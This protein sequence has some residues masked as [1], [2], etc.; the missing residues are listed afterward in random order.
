MRQIVKDVLPVHV[1]GDIQYGLNKVS[2]GWWVYV[3]SKKGVTKCTTMPQE[4]DAAETAKVTVEMRA[5][6][7]DS[8]RELR[9]DAQVVFNR[10]KHAFTIEVGPGVIRVVKIVTKPRHVINME[11]SIT[12]CPH[13]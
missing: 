6:Q 12:R 13:L 8:V 2:D 7:A 5:L 1:R 4:L 3:I 9:S 11:G 10:G